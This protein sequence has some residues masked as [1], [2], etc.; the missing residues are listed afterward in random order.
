MFIRILDVYEAFPTRFNPR[1]ALANVS[2]A[3][4]GQ[5]GLAQLPAGQ[6]KLAGQKSTCPAAAGQE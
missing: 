1:P 4:A 6:K 5:N 2:W 3:T